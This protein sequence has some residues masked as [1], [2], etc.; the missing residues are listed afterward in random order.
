M[1]WWSDPITFLRYQIMVIAAIFG[2]MCAAGIVLG[3][4][5]LDNLNEERQQRLEHE[6]AARASAD[7]ALRRVVLLERERLERERRRT[8]RG[9]K[10]ALDAAIDVLSDEQAA[11]IVRKGTRGD[12]G[13][14]GAAGYRGEPGDRGPVGARGPVGPRGP[15]GS[16]GSRGPQGPRGPEGPPGRAPTAQEVADAARA[17]LCQ[18]FPPS[19][20]RRK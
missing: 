10:A 14:R 18:I 12:K 9:V 4:Q 16:Q 6:Q 3:W 1:S 5:A 20:G 17:V 2:L 19:C 11:R 7:A 15:A 8:A 13:P